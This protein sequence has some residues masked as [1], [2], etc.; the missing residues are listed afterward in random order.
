MEGRQAVLGGGGDHVAPLGAGAD[1]GPPV[2][3]V[4]LDAL[5]VARLQEDRVL[6]GEGAGAVTG[7][8][9]GD[10]E[11]VIPGKGDDRDHVPHI[12][13][14]DDRSGPLVHCQVERLASGV[15]VGVMRGRN[16]A[17]KISDLDLRALH[18]RKHR[19]WPG[20]AHRGNPQTDPPRFYAPEN[21]CK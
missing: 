2:V 14:M 17:G 9:G 4:D 13:G 10:V 21:A 15:P 5:H 19:A 3:R 18:G 16:A 11:A 7:A 8:L 6:E 20:T 1:A 12:G